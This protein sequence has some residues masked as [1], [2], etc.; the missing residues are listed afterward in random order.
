MLLFCALLD[1][2]LWSPKLAQLADVTHCQTSGREEEAVTPCHLEPIT[3]IFISIA[4]V[5]FTRQHTP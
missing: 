3:M 4:I 5:P 1:Y 2:I